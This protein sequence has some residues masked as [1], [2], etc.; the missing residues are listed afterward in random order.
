VP[1]RDREH[2]RDGNDDLLSQVVVERMLAG[3]ATRRHARGSEP[4]GDDLDA[5]ATSTSGSSVSRRFKAATD[6]QLD[7]LLGRDRSE[8][9]LAGLMLDGGHLTD[10]GCVVALAIGADGTK[11]P[12]GLWSG[13]TENKTV[14]TALLADLLARPATPT[15]GCWS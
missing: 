2:A 3:V 10:A 1:R 15:A 13:D 7:E 6:P 11:V 8:L 12:I 14:V 4:V 5:Q 9:D